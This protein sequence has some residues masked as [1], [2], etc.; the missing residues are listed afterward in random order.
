VK[1]G[2]DT[3]VVLRLLVNDV[4]EQ[5]TLAREFLDRLEAT[6]QRA[7]ISDLVVSEAYHG[8]RH[9]LKVPTEAALLMLSQIL[10][11]P[12]IK[13]ESAP[14][15]LRD[16]TEAAARP[17]FMDQLILAHHRDHR[18]TLLTFD[19]TLGALQGAELLAGA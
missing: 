8:L 19:R 10:A 1:Y 16:L 3:N 13:G 2:L 4:P 9:H 5:T 12:A 18:T 11:D 15:V 7:T 14:S 17:G 6:G